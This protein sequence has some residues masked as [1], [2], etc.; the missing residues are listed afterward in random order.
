MKMPL[1]LQCLCAGEPVPELVF[2]SGTEVII[3]TLSRRVV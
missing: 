2:K 3:V 1:L